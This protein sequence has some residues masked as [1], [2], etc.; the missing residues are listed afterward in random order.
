MLN[1]LYSTLEQG[2][3]QGYQIMSSPEMPE[4]IKAIEAKIMLGKVKLMEETMKSFGFSETEDYLPY[5]GVVQG[6]VDMIE[7]VNKEKASTMKQ[8]LAGRGGM[9]G[10][11]AG[12]MAPANDAGMASGQG[13]GNP[14]GGLEAESGG[15]GGPTGPD[16]MPDIEG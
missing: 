7:S 4:E 8:Q 6:M 14:G 5:M 1:Q 16:E 12:G 3:L 11:Q 13:Y 15:I 9:N 10:G 2:L